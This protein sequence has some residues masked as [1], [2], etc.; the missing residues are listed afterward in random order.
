M[1]AERRKYVLVVHILI[2]PL[3]DKLMRIDE[4]QDDAVFDECCP[5]PC[6]HE[7]KHHQCFW[8]CGI[9]LIAVFPRVP[10]C[11]AENLDEKD[12][13]EQEQNQPKT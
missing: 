1:E 13:E 5:L 2:P 10:L 8:H 4:G 6:S 7:C 12:T 11:H 3:S 9:V